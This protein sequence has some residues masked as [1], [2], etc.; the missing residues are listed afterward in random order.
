MV[1][2][3]PRGGCLETSKFGKFRDPPLGGVSVTIGIYLTSLPFWGFVRKNERFK[4]RHTIEFQ[5]I[6]EARFSYF[7]AFFAKTVRY[8]THQ[9]MQ[10]SK[11]SGFYFY[12]FF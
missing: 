6:N 11:N 4:T 1:T 12:R 9:T 7:F 10:V 8:K 3:A 2:D 5:K